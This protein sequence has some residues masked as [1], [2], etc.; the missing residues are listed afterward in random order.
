MSQQISGVR[1]RLR[2]FSIASVSM[3]G[4]LYGYNIGAMSG[5][6]PILK[7]QMALTHFKISLFVSSFLWGVVL[8]MFA[9]W[10][11]A[12]LIGRKRMLAV[13]MIV[14]TIGIIITI[15]AH[16]IE[17]IV[18]GRFLVGLAAGMVT[19][20]VPLY[21]SETVPCSLRGRST[22]A[23]QLFLTFGILLSTLI[24]WHFVRLE[25]WRPIFYFEFIPVALLFLLSFCIPESPRWLVMHGKSEK[26][27]QILN[28]VRSEEESQSMLSAMLLSKAE[29]QQHVSRLAVIKHKQYLWPLF[30]V[31]ALGSLNQ[32]TGINAILQYDSTILYF[33]GFTEHNSALVG[34]VLI[35]ALNFIVTIIAIC[36]VDHF[37]RRTLLRL[38]L[39]G[40]I[41]CLLAISFLHHFMPP[42][43]LKAELV[44]VLLLG[45]IIFFA[46]APGATV[47]AFMSEL[48]P[49]KVRTSG[50][51]IAVLIASAIGAL[52]SAVFLPLQQLIGF[53]GVFLFCACTSIL[54]LAT[55]YFLPQ[56]NKRSLEEIERG[57]LRKK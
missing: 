22:V 44:T 55:T 16:S 25:V 1:K 2:V 30:L 10:Y 51:S 28:Q 24:S 13:A 45:F 49:T 31:V 52:L 14:A 12:D 48:L 53:S 43:P 37:D 34:S 19:T 11:L 6:L 18:G 23:F 54:Y 46:I 33:S 29:A 42:T 57:M 40:L 5:V 47:W 3:A 50:N 15:V 36:I 27:L 8:I 32:L 4:C 21:L 20:T 35:T 38:G 9:M 7:E 56:T 17:G 39:V 41:I 26:A